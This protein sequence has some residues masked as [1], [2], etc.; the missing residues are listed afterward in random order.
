MLR[1]F[2]LILSIT[3]A[4]VLLASV[5]RGQAQSIGTVTSVP[6]HFRGSWKL[7]SVDFIAWTGDETSIIV[8][9]AYCYF[10]FNTAGKMLKYGNLP[11]SDAKLIDDNYAVITYDP[12]QD[13]AFAVTKLGSR[14][15]IYGKKRPPTVS[16]ET[17]GTYISPDGQ[18]LA[19]SYGYPTTSQPISIFDTRS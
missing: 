12:D 19:L 13:Y 7:S 11:S 16:P 17:I 2:R 1:N 18:R 8:E 9:A 14:N 5:S 6:I 3:T 10:V 15:V 4:I